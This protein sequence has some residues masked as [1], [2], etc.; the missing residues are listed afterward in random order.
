MG[1][2]AGAG[3]LDLDGS[4]PTGSKGTRCQ[5]HDGPVT[6]A[7]TT[8]VDSTDGVAVAA[9]D[10]GAV[11]GAGA[12]VL[13]AHATGFCGAVWRPF[14]HA[15][16]DATPGHRIVALDF[17]GHGDSTAPSEHPYSWDGFADDV[18]AVVD[19]LGLERPIGVGHSKGGA[20]LVLAEQRRP[21]TFSRLWLF[22]P[23]IMPPEIAALDGRN[24]LAEGALRRRASFP[25]R[26]TAIANYASKPPMDR[27]DPEAREAYVDGAFR[28]DDD[29][30]LHLKCR[31][32]VESQVYRM[33]SQ[34]RAWDR[35]GDLH[36][37]VTVVR[38]AVTEPGPAAFADRVA[39][40]IPGAHLVAME[41]LGH[42]GPL[43]APAELGRA[44]ARA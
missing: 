16:A 10:L 5:R 19:R 39:A 31:P 44:A 27:F 32:A 29:G 30:S 25:D 28:V 36:L 33:G 9:T 17:R 8:T 21:G 40:S 26:A 2:A 11:P 1:D 6:D 7:V 20:A 41:H 37:P 24:P 4:A 22:E 12:P 35:L 14:A 3:S 34:H 42:F 18:L 38:G 15:F 43:E 23:V 13:L